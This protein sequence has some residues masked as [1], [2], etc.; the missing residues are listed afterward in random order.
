M[1]TPS[2]GIISIFFLIIF[3]PTMVGCNQSQSEQRS[4]ARTKMAPKSKK[5]AQLG[6]VGHAEHLY[7]RPF[8]GTLLWESWLTIQYPNGQKELKQL[9]IDHDDS[10]PRVIERG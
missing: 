9:G 5:S 4:K 10:L 8:K 6:E 2:V 3:I 1:K 7:G